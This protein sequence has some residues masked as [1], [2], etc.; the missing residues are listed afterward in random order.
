M[1][2]K[3]PEISDL[4]IS[5]PITSDILYQA[6]RFAA[7]Q[8][9]SQITERVWLNTIA[10]SAVNNYLNMLGIQTD[11][12]ASDSWNP[13]MQL[14]SDSADLEISGVGKLECRPVKINQSKCQIPLEVWDLRIGYTVVEI[15]DLGKKANILGFISEVNTEE[16]SL[17]ALQ[18]PEALL[19]R[20]HELQNSAVDNSIV[21]LGNWLDNIFDA[22]WQTIS[23]LLLPERITPAL[24][25]RTQDASNFEPADSSSDMGITRAKEIDLGVQLSD[26]RVVLLIRLIP[27]ENSQI[28]VT[29]QVHPQPNELYLPEALTLRILEDFQEVFMEAQARSQDNFIQL[30]FSGQPGERFTIEI[31]LDDAKFSEQFQ[32]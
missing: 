10:I 11:L 21:N 22:G 2:P 25:F 4:A 9:N 16:L 6:D 29:L 27:E 1:T 28:G 17:D 26:R 18:P 19:D 32:L 7:R 12:T 3:S 23:S 30:Q 5:L 13:V 8:P 15:D 24:G 31:L 14:C 20:I